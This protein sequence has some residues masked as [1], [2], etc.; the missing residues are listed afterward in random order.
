MQ[1]YFVFDG[2]TATRS[3]PETPPGGVLPPDESAGG[4]RRGTGRVRSGRLLA[5]TD[6]DRH[7]LA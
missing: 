6:A 1:G 5:A 2:N 3:Q 7:A 4:R